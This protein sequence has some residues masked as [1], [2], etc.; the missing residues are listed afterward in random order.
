MSLQVEKVLSDIIRIQ[1]VN[2][3]GGETAVAEYLKKLFD[4]YQIP[5]EIIESRP[6]RGSFIASY[7]K[8]TKSLL[9]LSHTDVV[10][11]GEGWSFNPFSGEIKDG[12]VHGRGAIDCKGM[13]AA[14]TCAFINLV[15]S[16]K[17]KGKLIF[18]A[19]ADEE[20]GGA[21]GAGYITE[22]FPEKIRADFSINEGAEPIKINGHPYHSLS[23]GEKAPSWIRLKTKGIAGHGSSPVLEYNAAVKMARVIT[24]L[25]GYQPKIVLTPETMR[26]I[27][28]IA[29]IHGLRVQINEN[30]ID[31]TIKKFNDR[32][33]AVYLRVITRMTISPNV[34]HGGTK[35]NIVPD[36]C[37]AEVDI[38][39]LPNQNF[40]YVLREIKPF[41]GD[42]AVEPLQ[43]HTASFS[44]VDNDYYK[45]IETTLKEFVGNN[46][47]LP[48]VC[49]GAT[50]S[51]YLREIGVPAYGTGVITL[52]CDPA[53]EG[54]VHGVNEK[55]DIASL[56]LKTRFLK[57]LATKYLG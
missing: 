5:N 32:S 18:A 33:L 30:N 13:V 54:S 45:L 25:A 2:P 41:I 12:F 7:G 11:V 3:P 19:V 55:I 34:I 24:G 1:S 15:N 6:G 31:E 27:Q 36:T 44:G 29:D 17:I 10:P 35:T 9:F 52:N 43:V 14:E 47:V 49:T 48:S 28:T 46:P 8:G 21:L 16:D 40:D 50:D 42:S 22:K 23:I 26:L 57:K 56:Q 37:E 51:R 53:L 20:V 4:E 39:V 38:R